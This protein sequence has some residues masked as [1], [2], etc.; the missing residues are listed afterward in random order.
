MKRISLAV[1]GKAL[2]AESAPT[3]SQAMGV[4]SR[5]LRG[6]AMPPKKLSVFR[7]PGFVCH[8]KRAEIFKFF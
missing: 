5:E 7:E 2:I 3:M 8:Q 4:A 6:R 1:Y